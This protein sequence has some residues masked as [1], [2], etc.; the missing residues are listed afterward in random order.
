MYSATIG[1]LNDR[2]LQYLLIFALGA[3]LGLASFVSFLKYLLN[4]RARPTLVLLA[5]LMFGSLRALWP[6]QGEDRE[7]VS[8]YS[9][10][11]TAL[12]LFLAGALIV[13]FLVK[14]EERVGEGL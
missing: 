1:A 6:W 3:L 10:E 12:L 14:V 7:L 11:L 4:Q 9:S 2:D 13:A 8:P 5:G